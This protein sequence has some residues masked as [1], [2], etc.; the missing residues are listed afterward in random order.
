MTSNPRYITVFF[1]IFAILLSISNV[2]SKPTFVPT[3]IQNST[4]NT[5][6]IGA[7]V[8]MT[9]R[10][11][12]EARVAMEIAIDEFSA[13][14]M[15]NVTL[16][17]RNSKGN[18][19][20]AIR[21]ACV[22]DYRRQSMACKQDIGQEGEQ[23]DGDGDGKGKNVHWRDVVNFFFTNF[24]P[25]WNKDSLHELFTD[26]GD[27]ADVYV[28]RKMSKA[29][30][31]FEKSSSKYNEGCKKDGWVFDI[32][33]K[34]DKLPARNPSSSLD[35]SRAQN[36][37]D[38]KSFVIH[39]LLELQSLLGSSFSVSNCKVEIL[40]GSRFSLE[41]ESKQEG[42]ELTRIDSKSTVEADIKID[43]GSNLVGG[44]LLSTSEKIN[45][46][47]DCKV[48]VRKDEDFLAKNGSEETETV[49]S[50]TF[51]AQGIQREIL[52]FKSKLANQCAQDDVQL[53]DND[54]NY[55]AK[56]EAS[57]SHEVKDGLFRPIPTKQDLINIIAYARGLDLSKSTKEI[58]D[59]F[60]SQYPVSPSHFATKLIDTHKVEVI[61]GLQTLE[62]VLSVGEIT[63]EG[64]IPTFSLLDSVPQWALDRL[65]FLVQ[66]S[67]SQVAQMKAFVS[68]MESFELN[69]FNFIYEDIH[70]SST[71]VIPQL[72]DAIKETSVEMSKIVKLSPSSS[73]YLE[74]LE[75]MN[76]EQCRVFL[77][78]ASLE[79]G[80][81]LFQNAKTVGMM[82]RGYVWITTNLNTDLLHTV[83]PSTFTIMEG[84]VGLGSFF[85]ETGSRFHDFSKRFQ[86]RFKFEQPEEEEEATCLGFLQYSLMMLHGEIQFINRKST[87][88]R[89]LQI[90]NVIGKYY[91]EVGYWSEGLGFSE[92]IN[93]RASYD[94]SLQSLGI[95]YWPGRPLSPPIG[96]AIPTS[97]NPLRVGVP[98]MTV[99]KQFV[100]VKY[101]HR[102][103]NFSF[104]GYSIELFKETVKQLPYYLPYE[105][106][107]FNGSYDSLVEQVYLKPFTL[108]MWAVTIMVYIYNGF[109]VGLI[110]RQH[111]QQNPENPGQLHMSAL[112][113]TWRFIVSAL[114]RFFNTTGDDLSGNLTRLIFVVWI[115]AAIIIG[116]CYTASLTSMLTVRILAP[117]VT[118]YETLKNSNAVVGYGRG[119]HVASY[120]VDVLPKGSPMLPD[121]TK[122]LLNVSESGTLQKIEK[123]MLGS[124][125][126]VD[127]SAND[128]SL[129]LDSFWSLFLLTGVTSTIALAIH[130]GTI[131]RTHAIYYGT[132]LQSIAH[133]TYNRIRLPA[134]AIAI[135]LAR[136]PH[137]AI[138]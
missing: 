12:K 130:Y 24:P 112:E 103:R 123:M 117:K 37:V 15:Q 25:E 5:F 124:E 101:D 119:A 111:A 2:Q 82:D 50:S 113:R 114:T 66:A 39:S 104:S 32:P 57:L 126:C 40:G 87:A 97:T 137:P 38:G 86:K 27:I 58:R 98:T 116:Q 29:G 34:S 53:D 110:E 129:G 68:I 28:A 36:T 69:R 134:I 10:A 44:D 90:I 62:E 75:R 109:V 102:D 31:R 18:L 4:S 79:T 11:G 72:I 16:Y 61:L 73:S 49:D 8:D 106:Y 74:E 92:V 93:E 64:Q 115:F 127:E 9:T 71:Q 14:T 43:S 81:R 70:S 131:L 60:F 45:K 91:K 54:R 47:N 7:I 138:E 83:N 30:K 76:I 48:T 105:F 67:P 78:H 132:R 77:V 1:I 23:D 80:I 100:N 56:D 33:S 21:E 121:F 41:F 13:K 84:V 59:G 99:F 128:E 94:A 95:I 35:S 26:V 6:A 133:A 20:R 107:P 135:A 22:F 88:S 19:I 118:D 122:A 52:N 51:P 46:P 136:A 63:G 42:Y 85:P 125:Q 120:L 108:G 65:P 17:T 3:S 96:W 89:T 55:V